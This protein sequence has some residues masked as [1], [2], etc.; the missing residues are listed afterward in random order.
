MNGLPFSLSYKFARLHPPLDI[1]GEDLFLPQEELVRAA[2]QLDPSG[3]NRNGHIYHATTLRAIQLLLKCREDI[4]EL[5]LS[6]D[7][8]IS[9][10]QIE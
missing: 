8:A 6:V 3:W 5:A 4:L 7:L 9:P 10:K 2:D 1:S